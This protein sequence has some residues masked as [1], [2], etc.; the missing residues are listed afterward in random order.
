MLKILG[1]NKSSYNHLASAYS[2]LSLL[3][4][5]QKKANVMQVIAT[6]KEFA[7]MLFYVRAYKDAG[8]ML[9]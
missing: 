7:T 9:K 2:L 8:E 5:E 4:D 3:S 1:R 6:K